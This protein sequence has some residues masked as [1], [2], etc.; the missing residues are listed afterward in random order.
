MAWLETCSSNP[1]S[2]FLATTSRKY[3]DPDNHMDDELQAT[4]AIMALDLSSPSKPYLCHNPFSGGSFDGWTSIDIELAF[5]IGFFGLSLPRPPAST[6]A[7]EVRLFDQETVLLTRLCR[8]PI[9]LI[10]PH[11]IVSLRHEAERLANSDIT[12]TGN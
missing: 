4:A 8:L 9:E 1:S 3:S 5:R 2:A 11:V 10:C 12:H 7:L 6:P